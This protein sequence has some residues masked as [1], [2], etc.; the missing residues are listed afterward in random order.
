M[1]RRPGRLRFFRGFSHHA[2]ACGRFAIGPG[3]NEGVALGLVEHELEAEHGDVV[4][5]SCLARQERVPE[6]RVVLPVHDALE[7]G[8][9]HPGERARGC[10]AGHRRFDRARHRTKITRGMRA[11]RTVGVPPAVSPR[12]VTVSSDCSSTTVRNFSLASSR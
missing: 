3:A 1:A 8:N 6:H 4:A 12:Q 10:E 5:H 11:R 2:G 7:Q 9:H